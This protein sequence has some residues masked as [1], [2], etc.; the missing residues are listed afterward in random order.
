MCFKKYSKTFKKV[1]DRIRE[2]C[3]YKIPPCGKHNLIDKVKKTLK[4][5]KK[6][7]DK[8]VFE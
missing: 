1:L 2:E 5:S 7:V 3:Y 6:V 8:S 4:I